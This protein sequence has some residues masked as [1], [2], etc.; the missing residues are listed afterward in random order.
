MDL[1][2]LLR[3]DGTKGAT[4]HIEVLRIGKDLAAAYGAVTNN[5]TVAHGGLG[6]AKRRACGRDKSVELLKCSLIKEHQDALTRRE[7]ATIVLLLVVRIVILLFQ[8]LLASQKIVVCNS[9]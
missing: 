4:H 6:L 3:M 5:D 9:H 7:L 2:D 8:L 1:D